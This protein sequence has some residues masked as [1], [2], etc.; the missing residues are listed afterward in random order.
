MEKPLIIKGPL[1]DLG[2][3][4]HIARCRGKK[5][6]NVKHVKVKPIIY[7]YGNDDYV[8]LVEPDGSDCSKASNV[9]SRKNKKKE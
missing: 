4:L 9:G 7:P 1:E 8:V 6:L 3:I 2:D 5:A